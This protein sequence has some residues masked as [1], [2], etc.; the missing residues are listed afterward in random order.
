MNPSRTASEGSEY[1]VRIE[2]FSRRTMIGRSAAL[3]G[4]AISATSLGGFLAACGSSDSDTDSGN[5][6][7]TETPTRGGTL[8]A[9]ISGEPDVLDPAKST[10]A[11]ASEVHNEI[12]SKLVDVSPEGEVIPQLATRWELTDEKTWVFTLVEGV[13][14]HNGDDFTADDVKYTFERIIDPKTKSS[15]AGNF[16]T[17]DRVEVISP[18]EVAFHLKQP[19]A[20]FLIALANY[21]Q[22]VSKRAIEAGGAERNPVGTG[23]FKFVEWARG[24][25]ITI[26]RFPEYHDKEHPFL[27]EV[28]INMRDPIPSNIDALRSG[29]LDF[30]DQVPAQS[31]KTVADDPDFNYVTAQ[32]AG[33][34]KFLA[35]GCE[36]APVDN[37]QLR[38]AIAWA[39]DRKAVRDGAFFG[40]GEEGSE[41]MPTGSPWYSDNDPFRQGPDIEKAKQLIAESGLQT[42]IEVE[43]L[44][45]TS[46]PDPTR[47][48]E[49]VREQLKEIGVELKIV[50]LE[51]SVWLERLIGRK[52]QMTFTFNEKT[53]DPDNIYS[54]LFTTDAPLNIFGWNNKEFDD[55]IARGRVSN[56]EDERKQIYTDAR[57]LIF[58][59]VPV[60][61][62]FY[63]TPNYL[64]PKNVVGST[65]RPNL[66]LHFDLI[67]F[68]E[69]S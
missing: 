54:Q 39:I 37:P 7:S 62:T 60:L 23:P 69:Q 34:P 31:I 30:L 40:A 2:P 65:V 48:G 17:L 11:V 49:I 5:D 46:R 61:F 10:L 56:D 19:F 12:F 51:L 13:K 41:E 33:L 26:E 25:H 59:E 14:F 52:Y 55:L 63:E 21:G 47:V 1:V 6:S 3:G 28:V 44:A 27:D 66:E 32:N 38:Q 22:I 8:N 16:G 15:F 29:E 50:P 9:A 20:P 58:E 35:F 36:N 64:M 67:G 4:A 68:T 45:N 24:D 42:P 53:I 43:Y 57:A 18:T